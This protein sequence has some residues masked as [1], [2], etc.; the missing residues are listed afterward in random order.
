MEGNSVDV[1]LIGFGYHSGFTKRW[2]ECLI[3][4]LL[5]LSSCSSVVGRSQAL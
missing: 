2:S 1:G 4:L 3:V 5:E